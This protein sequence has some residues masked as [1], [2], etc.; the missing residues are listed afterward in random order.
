[1]KSTPVG[2]A[3][4]KV[5]AALGLEATDW[6]DAIRQFEA[7]GIAVTSR[8]VGRTS[9]PVVTRLATSGG[10]WNPGGDGEYYEIRYK[11]I[12]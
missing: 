1:M 6:T 5:L 11:S 2:V 3:Q 12:D 7:H 9:E 8:R 10:G 4:Q